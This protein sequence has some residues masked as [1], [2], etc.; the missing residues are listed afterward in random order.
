MFSF[1]PCHTETIPNTDVKTEVRTEPSCLCT[2]TPLVSIYKYIG[3]KQEI[4]HL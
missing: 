4:I 1:S 3:L 2:V